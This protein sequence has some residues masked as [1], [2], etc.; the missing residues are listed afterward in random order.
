M[1][2]LRPEMAQVF[3][4]FGDPTRL[5]ILSQ[6][7]QGEQCSCD[8]QVALG[9]P[10]STLAHH[11]KVLFTAGIVVAR[12]SGRWIHYSIAPQTLQVAA[13]LLQD[14]ADSIEELPPFPAP[15]N[16]CS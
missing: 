2:R 14:M 7:Q 4:A 15:G 5:L 10:Q 13:E 3:G 16:C 11:M 12:R 9:I 8:M 6:L 1:T